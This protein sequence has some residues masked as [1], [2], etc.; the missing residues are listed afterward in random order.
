MS[1]LVLYYI[2]RC[3]L[4]LLCCCMA[5]VADAADVKSY[6]QRMEKLPTEEV[7]KMARTY[8]EEKDQSD[9]AIVCLTIVTKRYKPSMKGEELEPYLQAWD[10]LWYIYLSEYADYAKSKDCLLNYQRLAERAGQ[11][12]ARAWMMY[13]VMYETIAQ[14]TVDGSL[15][16]KA[17]DY[18]TK[19]IRAACSNGENEVLVTSFSNMASILD[20][21]GN[22]AMLD[23]QYKV[24]QRAKGDKQVTF[25]YQFATLLYQCVRYNILHEYAKAIEVSNKMLQLAGDSPERRRYWLYVYMHRGQMYAKLGKYDLAI[26]DAKM[27]EAI[28]ER[29]NMRDVKMLAYDALAKYYRGAGDSLRSADYYAKHIA[30]KDSLLSYRQM[31]S[32]REMAFADEMRIMEEQ[33]AASERSCR[34]WELLFVVAAFVA[35]VVIGFLLVLRRK[36]NRLRQSNEILYEKNQEML[37]RDEENRRLRQEEER[38][39]AESKEK[40]KGSSLDGE[41]KELLFAQLRDVME[42]TDEIYS[43][44]FSIDRLAE[45]AGVKS[46]SVSQVINELYGHNFNIFVNEYRIMEAC[47][48]MSDVAQSAHLTIEAIGNSVG[49]KSRNSFIT[50][51]KR[52]TGLTPSEYQAIAKQKA[53]V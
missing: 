22:L 7:L 21:M 10:K 24:L 48:R 30:L 43:S 9:S 1:R 17:I 27:L 16:A 26:A 4:L 14:Q 32:I 18:Y 6:Y 19:S 36:N 33:M 50:S 41:T 25:E 51:F 37:R 42:S 15:Y 47:K 3:L 34:Q 23:A 53:G 28:S 2:L 31:A 44:E 35:C 12:V 5:T 39:A 20:E 8:L 29:E 40:Y 46:K 11:Y 13:G 45:L 49:F 52:F 38:L